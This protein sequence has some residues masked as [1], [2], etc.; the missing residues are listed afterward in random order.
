M[1]QF[2]IKLVVWGCALVA[3]ALLVAILILAGGHVATFLLAFNEKAET[4]SPTFWNCLAGGIVA[5][6]LW[7]WW[8]DYSWRHGGPRKFMPNERSDALSPGE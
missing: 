2:C 5:T 3:G 1:R 4:P 6:G 8:M 7:G